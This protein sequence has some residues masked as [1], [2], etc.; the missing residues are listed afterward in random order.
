MKTCDRQIGDRRSLNLLE[1]RLPGPSAELPSNPSLCSVLMRPKSLLCGAVTDRR[2]FYHQIMVSREKAAGNPVGPA[3]P[4]SIASSYAAGKDLL[5][6]KPPKAR[7]AAGDE[8][9]RVSRQQ[10]PGD[11]VRRKRGRI[12]RS[13][14]VSPLCCRG[15]TVEWNLPPVLTRVSSPRPGFCVKQRDTYEKHGVR[16]SPEKD[17]LNA[18]L[19]SVAGAQIDSSRRALRDRLVTCAAPAERR[20]ALAWAS[21]SAAAFPLT[22][23]GLLGAPLPLASRSCTRSYT[24]R[25]WQALNRMSCS[26]FRAQQQMSSS[27][28]ACFPRSW[29]VTLQ[30]SSGQLVCF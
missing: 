10:A 9:F 8:L 18:L 2:D 1:R 27:L 19:F 30:P 6:R 23:R 17:V 12:T 28:P 4:V 20:C 24:V 15:T 22:T 25:M 7:E 5:C 11:K 26:G 13:S 16:G 29:P 14:R 21:L 3:M